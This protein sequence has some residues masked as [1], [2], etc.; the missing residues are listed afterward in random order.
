[1][2]GKA[3]A[4]RS[5]RSSKQPP[6]TAELLLFA[7]VSESGLATLQISPP[8]QNFEL[9]ANRVPQPLARA[10]AIR[11]VLDRTG[12]GLGADSGGPSAGRPHPRPRR[13]T[14]H[15]PPAIDGR[16]IDP[17]WQLGSTADDFWVSAWRQAPTDQTR[18]VV[19]YDDTTLYVAFACRTPGPTWCEPHS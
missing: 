19:L 15:Q 12:T 11:V 16:L 13:A 5:A 18:V 9:R 17:A 2:S 10:G 4:R 7:S 3:S 8:N 6:G 1:M 14:H